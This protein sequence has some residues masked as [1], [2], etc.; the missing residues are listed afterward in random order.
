M[1][2][3][4]D[5][6]RIHTEVTESHRN[7]AIYY[8]EITS[9]WRLA[10]GNIMPEAVYLGEQWVVTQNSYTFPNEIILNTRFTPKNLGT[11]TGELKFRDLPVPPVPPAFKATFR[12]ASDG[13]SITLPLVES[14]AEFDFVYDFEVDW[15]D[16]NSDTITAYDQAERVHTYSTAGDHQ[17]S[18]SGF[19]PMWNFRDYSASRPQIIS[20]DQVGAN[21]LDGVEDCSGMFYFCTEI[22]GGSGF[23]SLDVSNVIN[24]SS[25]FYAAPKFDQDIISWDVSNV[26]N[27]N[28]MFKNAYEFNQ[29]ISS[30]DVSNVIDMEGMF[31]IARAFNQDIGSWD[32]SSA[33]YMKQMF[34]NALAFNQDIG[35]WDVSSVINM[36]QMFNGAPAFNQ[37][38]SSWNVSNV[39]NMAYMFY[40]IT[41]FNQN[42]GSWD[43][44]SV[45]NMLNM[46][47]YVTISTANY[48]ALLEGWSALTLQ[49]GVHFHGGNSKYSAGAP[50]IAREDII[51]TYSWSITDGGE[52]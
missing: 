27:M 1:R 45:T 20:I 50:A 36:E 14:G 32:V 26:T 31:F 23:M 52:E 44:S 28:A 3:K 5:P 11:Q 47:K 18:V 33:I 15:G 2:K 19:M 30:W 38:I 9:Q 21:F 10:L 46:F 6:S 43:V 7:E 29:D 4:I 13:D 42:I 24:M 37:D 22:V 48:N 40:G 17:I 35:S 41:S 25:M 49:N 51:S 39:N 16:G 8:D 34:Y 12:T